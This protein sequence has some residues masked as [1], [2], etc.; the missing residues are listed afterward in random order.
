MFEQRIQIQEGESL[1][2]SKMLG[3][4]SLTAWDETDVLIRLATGA[5]ADLQVEQADGGPSVSARVTAEV[6]MPA[7]VPARVGE[8]KGNLS[9][10]GISSLAAQQVRGGLKLSDVGEASLTEVYGGVKARGLKSLS[11]VGTIFGSAS[12][13]NVENVDL[14]NVRGSLVAKSVG[15]LRGSRIGGSL[16]AK[17]VEGSLNVDEVGGNA[18]LK[19]VGA[20]VHLGQVAGNLTAKNLTGGAKVLTIGGNLVLGGEIGPARSYHFDARGNAILRLPEEANASLTLTAGGKFI[21]STELTGEVREGRTLSG[22]IGD[23]GAEIAVE[24]RGNVI[25][26]DKEGTRIEVGAGAAEEFVR[27]IEEGLSAIDLDAIGRQVGAEMEEAMSRLQV[28]LEGVDW[29]TVGARAQQA[30]ERAMEQLQRNM[31]RMAAR[32]ARQQERFERKMEREKLR[33]MRRAEKRH[34]REG[35]EVEVEFAMADDPAEEPYEEYEAEPGPD[36]DEERL[37]ILRMLEQGQIAPEEAEM[38]LDALQ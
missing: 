22:I 15:R 10:T 32:A 3:N 5:E 9:A 28:K 24:A 8:A 13:R 37:S 31:D 38:L 21:I 7:A 14:Q 17:D 19:N 36:L 25:L 30:T 26:G 33:A 23:G 1:T 6:Y 27:Q 12:L 18:T 35:G 29:E 2:L 11:V 20:E 4:A 16:T 34:M